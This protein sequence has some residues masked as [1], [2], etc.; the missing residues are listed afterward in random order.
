MLA[1][2]YAILIKNQWP[3]IAFG[4]FSIFFGNIGQ[5]FFISWYGSSIKDALLLSD[6]TYGGIYAVATMTSSVL[7]ITFGGVVDRIRVDKLLVFFSILLTTA[8]LLMY[9]VDSIIGL[10]IV[11]FLLRF[12]GQGFLPHIAQATVI[13]RAEQDKGKAISLV[14]SGVALGEVVLPSLLIALIA[15][16]GWRESW[17][18]IAAATLFVFLPFILFLVK[19]ADLKQPYSGASNA[20]NASDASRR[21]VIKDWR[22]WMIIP[23]ALIT[24]FLVTGVFIQQDFILDAKHW[25]PSVLAGSFVFYGA[26]H[27]LS[28]VVSGNLIDKYRSRN[29]LILIPI[30]LILGLIVIANVHHPIAA[31]LFMCLFG[32]AI[33]ATNP[34]INTLWAEM[35]GVSHIGAIRSLVT[36]MMILSTALAP[37]IF[38][39]MID[40]GWTLDEVAYALI[41][42]IFSFSLLLVP[43]YPRI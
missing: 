6:A 21:H 5:S 1:R 28:S 17:L 13:K 43:V 30:P 27:W 39:V 9:S 20:S 2:S 36:G 14:G 12:C 10:L 34:V 41:G 3:L 23:L 33:G 22:F 15:F 18:F 32:L 7:V 38:G 37:W 11:F 42:L 26:V 19:K 29:V 16:L 25:A 31:P 40:I 8:C 4:F 24:P 35:Y